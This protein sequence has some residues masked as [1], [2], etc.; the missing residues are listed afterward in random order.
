MTNRNL[1]NDAAWSGVE[2]LHS[3]K[4]QIGEPA[5]DEDTSVGDEN[6]QRT[7]LASWA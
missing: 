7:Y 1:P 4:N 2:V 5:S 6:R 3:E